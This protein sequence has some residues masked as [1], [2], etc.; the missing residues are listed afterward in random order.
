MTNGPPPCSLRLDEACFAAHPDWAKQA[1]AYRLLMLLL[2]RV[3]SRRLHRALIRFIIPPDVDPQNWIV[4][5]PGTIIPPDAQPEGPYLPGDTPP[6][7][8]IIPPGTVFPPEWTPEDPPPSGVVI[9]PGTVFPPDW[10]PPGPLPPGVIPPGS[11]PPGTDQ[12]GTTPPL[13]VPPWEPGPLKRPIGGAPGVTITTT[14]VYGS[15]SDGLMRAIN[16]V[17][18]TARGAATGQDLDDTSSTE[19]AATASLRSGANYH[20]WRSWL[21]MD[22]STIPLTATITAC[23]LKLM[24]YDTAESIMTVVEGTQADPLTTADFNNFTG[25]E[26]GHVTWALGG[27]GVPAANQ[28]TFNATGL[29]YLNTVLGGTAKLCLREYT[30]DYLNV[31]PAA[32]PPYFRNGMW[33]QNTATVAN[34]PHLDLTY[35]T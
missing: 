6:D 8:V 3:L 14:T 23:V 10:T 18:A 5:P 1:F 22:L 13:Y 33:Y 2:P 30:Y 31:A 4:L 20:I 9:P 35:Q 27:G 29:T 19:V 25:A 24:S 28:I 15:T 26:F 12:T 16:T 32:G 34:R 11:L 7:G 21:F 17:W